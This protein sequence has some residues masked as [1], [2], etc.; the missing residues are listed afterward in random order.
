MTDIQTLLTQESESI[1]HY[2]QSE[3]RKSRQLDYLQNIVDIHDTPQEIYRLINKYKHDLE[4]LRFGIT[5][6]NITNI[7]VD[8]ESSENVI[9]NRIEFAGYIDN[10][11]CTLTIK[12]EDGM[13]M[14]YVLK[15]SSENVIIN[16]HTHPPYNGIW[17]VAPPSEMDIAYLITEQKK[18]SNIIYNAVSTREGIYIYY[19]HP[20]FV[21]NIG[22]FNEQKIDKIKEDYQHFKNDLGYN[23]KPYSIN[24]GSNLSPAKSYKG[25][26]N[27]LADIKHPIITINEFIQKLNIK[28]IIIKLV[29][30]FNDE[31]VNFD[32][33]EPEDF[34]I[35]ESEDIL[36]KKS[37]SIFGDINMEDEDDDDDVFD[38]NKKEKKEDEMDISG[39]SKTYPINYAIHHLD[40]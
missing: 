16:Y 35:D 22:L 38:D 6:T 25:D 30:Y 7:G 21:Q 20:E 13:I 23:P 2:V 1:A 14:G 10:T 3:N 18:T 26:I 8:I 39:G 12:G 5:T 40:M 37:S 33:D 9:R 32:I 34:D 27:H 29:D 11:K 36:P 28:G 24:G 4:Q 17:P 19:L 31:P 15:P